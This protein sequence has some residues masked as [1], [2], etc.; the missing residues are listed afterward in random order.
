[1]EKKTLIAYA[2]WA[3]STAEVAEEIGKALREDGLDVD[4]AAAGDVDDVSGY[5]AVVLGTAIHAGRVH[6][7]MRTFLNEHSDSLSGLPVAYFVVCLT[8]KEDTDQNRRKAE[9]FLDGI[10]ADFP[11]VGPVDVGLFGGAVSTDTEK[12]KRLPFAQR[13]IV[14]AMKSSAGDFRDWDA[15]RAWAKALPGALSRGMAPGA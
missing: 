5:G 1:M 14:R 12:L 10:R 2:S 7:H 8:M 13:M 4:V 9:A 6:K 11:G 3:G 15:I